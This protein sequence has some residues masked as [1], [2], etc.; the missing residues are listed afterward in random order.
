MGEL[1]ARL[2]IDSD[3]MSHLLT[4]PLQCSN[5]IARG[6]GVGADGQTRVERVHGRNN[7]RV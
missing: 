2:R 3:T 1:V 5:R 4:Y 6:R 7:E